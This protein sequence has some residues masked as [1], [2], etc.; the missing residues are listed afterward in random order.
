VVP[1]EEGW[2]RP[3]HG[4][5]S[6]E[7][8]SERSGGLPSE[9][10]GGLP[11]EL[12]GGLRSEL[13]GKRP[14]ELPR[15]LSTELVGALVA[16]LVGVA[17][18]TVFAPALRGEFLNFD[19]RFLYV[20]NPAYRGFDLDHL[21]W[22]F[23]STRLGHYAPLT[24]LS[25]ALDAELFG[26]D[27]RAF[28]RTNLLL[29]AANA[30]LFTLLALALFRRARPER[31]AAHPVALALAA[32]ASAL[33]FA[34]HPLRV[35]SVAWITERRGLLATFFL[36]LALLAWL[37]ACAPG[38]AALRSRP[39]Y[40]LALL[41]LAASLLAKGL[42]MTF[43]AI[44]VVL[45]FWP[46]R[47]AS[48][49]PAWR[50]KLLPLALGVA[51]AI[52]SGWA[53]GSAGGTV[54][55]LAQWG[56]RERVVQSLY[57]LAF[58]VRET[59][60]PAA[61]SPLHELPYRLD[62]L[63]PRFLVPVVLVPI[64][65][66]A[67]VVFRARVPALAA[68]AAVYAIALAPVLGLAQAGPQLVADRYSYVACM[69]W[70][71]LA[72]GL[73]FAAWSRPAARLVAGGLLL[74]VLGALVARTRAEIPAW[75]DSRSLWERV[76]AGREPSSI[77]HNNLGAMD[78]DAGRLESAIDHLR[79]SVAIRPDQGRAWLNLGK[80]LVR[81]NQI[82]EAADALRTASATLHPAHEALVELGNLYVNRLGRIDDAVAV[83]RTAVAEVESLDRSHF[84]PLPYLG[85]GVALLRQGATDEGRRRLEFAAQFP[86][87][88]ERALRALRR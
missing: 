79:A 73:L 61:L 20:E 49:R 52:A 38:E 67:L 39:A 15:S 28:H 34:L 2:R 33:L 13:P 6:S 60:W 16:L 76:L 55:T 58:Y 62:P 36:L 12:P 1:Q 14:S 9:R 53:A 27:A 4:E 30:A 77:A 46:L 82:P 11:S 43:V 80:F 25:A 17:T 51:S 72:G 35:E 69:P 47:R 83:F 10:S 74:A 24:W 57:G 56:V 23:R 21:A 86:E 8:P 42:G 63:E 7:L 22:M 81:A 40:A 88:R 32:G 71:L 31:A 65:A 87:T 78:G 5:L 41:A 59:V 48:F 19:D 26:L 54:R 68:A 50:Q 18:W 37:R 29:H 3:R 85:L 45:D 84:S 64:V 66:V 44:V 70:A 75:H